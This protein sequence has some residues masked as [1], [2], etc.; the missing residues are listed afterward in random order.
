MIPFLFVYFASYQLPSTIL[1]AWEEALVVSPSVLLSD[2]LCE[3]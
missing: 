1:G 2:V 3:R